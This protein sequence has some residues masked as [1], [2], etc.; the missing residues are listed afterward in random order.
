M[1]PPCGKTGPTQRSAHR[2]HII[3]VCCIAS[4]T[5]A[6][7][8]AISWGEGVTEGNGKKYFK[9][10]K[11]TCSSDCHM[12]SIQEATGMWI[13]LKSNLPASWEEYFNVFQHCTPSKRECA[14]CNPESENLE[15]VGEVVYLR[16]TIC[17]Q[18]SK[19]RHPAWSF[20]CVHYVP[21][22]IHK[23]GEVG[24]CPDTTI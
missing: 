4:R 20:P 7:N 12:S 19:V 6:S 13:A 18:W 3:L 5:L 15:N 2:S 21:S 17:V 23:S 10:S 22:L 14:V 9:Y 1:S 11:S 16:R 24:L 8:P